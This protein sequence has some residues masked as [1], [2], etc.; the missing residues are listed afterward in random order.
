MDACYAA[1]RSWPVRSIQLKPDIETDGSI[2]RL[3]CGCTLD[4][5]CAWVLLFE[6]RG[7]PEGEPPR[8]CRRQVDAIGIAE[9][10]DSWVWTTG[11]GPRKPP[12]CF[13]VSVETTTSATCGSS[14]AEALQSRQTACGVPVLAGT[15]SC[16][17][18]VAVPLQSSARALT[19]LKTAIP[20][21]PVLHAPGTWICLWSPRLGA[22]V[23]DPWH[24]MSVTVPSHE[25]AARGVL[26]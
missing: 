24:L 1:E 10:V 11:R 26:L 18:V 17:A 16:R 9:R 6:N 21:P 12:A 8:L 3:A 4:A 15:R 25:A 19:A 23:D 2:E 13:I 14:G 7:D 5:D 22:E 20:S